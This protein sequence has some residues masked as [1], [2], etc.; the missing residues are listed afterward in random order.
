MR[1]ISQFIGVKKNAL[2]PINFFNHFAIRRSQCD[3]PVF[4]SHM[5]LYN[6][7]KIP[8]VLETTYYA[9]I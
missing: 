5:G 4:F 2:Q 9:R 3:T 8:I 1:L 7:F 6:F